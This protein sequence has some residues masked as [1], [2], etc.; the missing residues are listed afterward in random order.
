M[1]NYL[2]T[3]SAEGYSHSRIQEHHLHYF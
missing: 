3:P 2:T 1:A